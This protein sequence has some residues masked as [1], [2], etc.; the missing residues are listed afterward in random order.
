MCALLVGVAN[1]VLQRIQYDWREDGWITSC[2]MWRV[3][4]EMRML[5]P[6]AVS[7]CTTRREKR[8]VT[9]ASDFEV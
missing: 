7:L 1:D 8:E 4:R 3:V 9:T 6:E 2:R 5:R